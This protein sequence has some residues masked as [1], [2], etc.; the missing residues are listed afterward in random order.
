MLKTLVQFEIVSPQDFGRGRH[1][2]AALRRFPRA[3]RLAKGGGLHRHKLTI[4]QAP[5]TASL[6]DVTAAS[7]VPHK[8]SATLSCGSLISENLE[9]GI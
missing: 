6:G 3:V 4:L 7:N 8:S 5:G 2:A 1:G 9:T